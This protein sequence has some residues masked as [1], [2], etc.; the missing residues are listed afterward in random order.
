MDKKEKLSHLVS[1]Q[2]F[3][4]ITE[5]GKVLEQDL[6]LTG[7]QY[8]ILHQLTYEGQKTSSE[9]AEILNVTLP[10]VTNLSNK[11]VSK[12]YIERVASESDRRQVLLSVTDKGREV[13]DRLVHRYKEITRELWADLTE[14]EVDAL[15]SAYEK[16]SKRLNPKSSN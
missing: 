11:L 4:I 8:Y 1:R 6:T 14:Q 2:M 12:G 3:K 16:V 9:L 10:A 5:Y 13:E 15:I 7:P